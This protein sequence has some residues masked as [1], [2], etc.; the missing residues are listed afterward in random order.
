M[1]RPC[2]ICS[3]GKSDEIEQAVARGESF[4]N[5]AKC[6]GISAAS[7]YRHTQHAVKPFG[8]PRARQPDGRGSVSVKESL[9]DFS[10]MREVEAEV[11]R[12]FRQT[13]EQTDLA[14]DRKQIYNFF[15]GVG[16]QTNQL[17]FLTKLKIAAERHQE[18]KMPTTFSILYVGPI[19][20]HPEF[21]RLRGLI[22]RSSNGNRAAVEE[23]FSMFTDKPGVAG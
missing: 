2:K 7:V 20:S 14:M 17:E 1:P 13:Q 8:T 22:L 16:K 4:R 23:V 10:T 15:M 5:V 21:A 12:I 11:I 18:E 19:R 6:F 9:G 3:S